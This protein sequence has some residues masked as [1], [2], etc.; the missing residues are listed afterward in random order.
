VGPDGDSESQHIGNLE[1]QASG[2]AVVTT[3]H[4]AIPEF[5]KD[6]VTGVVVPQ[7]DPVGLALALIAVLRDLDYCQRLAEAAV[8]AASR[9]DV[10]L[11]ARRHN[12]IYGSLVRDRVQ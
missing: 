5:V 8:T 12:E 10:T 7:N 6:G 11:A 4:G 1:A 3:D 2:R 9:L